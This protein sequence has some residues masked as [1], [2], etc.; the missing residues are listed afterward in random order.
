MGESVVRDSLPS[1]FPLLWYKIK[2]ILATIQSFQG[3]TYWGVL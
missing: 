2:G 1:D 3:S